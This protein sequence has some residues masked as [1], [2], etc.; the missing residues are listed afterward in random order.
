MK[1]D[2]RIKN[3]ITIPLFFLCSM[4][5]I[6]LYETLAEVNLTFL[7]VYPVSIKG[8]GGIVSMPLVHANYEHLL[9][10]SLPFFLLASALFYFYPRIALRVFALTWLLTGAF[11]W[12]SGREAYHI[13]ASGLV[14]GYAAFLFLSGVLSKDKALSAIA[15]LVWFLYG[16]MVWGVLPMKEEVSW[17]GHLFGLIVGVVQAVA[18]RK[19]LIVKQID[20]TISIHEDFTYT[21][22]SFPTE[23]KINYIFIEDDDVKPENPS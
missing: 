14:Y 3:S 2:N 16:G 18:F 15:L 9:A 4:W 7:G 12:L 8:L 13:G 1:I 6:K 10:N 5:L 19:E 20:E 17:E 21:S 22:N 23:L 11:V